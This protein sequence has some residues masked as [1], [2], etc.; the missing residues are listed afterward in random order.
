MSNPRSYDDSITDLR[1][2]A[3]RWAL[4]A[5]D[6]ARESKTHT[7]QRD[8][9][10]AAHYR[11]MAETYYK[12]ALELAEVVKTMPTG[13][14]VVAAPQTVDAPP[15]P[16]ATPYAAVSINE[17]MRI[18]D[19]AG[20]SARDVKQHKDNVFSA[21]FSRWQPVSERE[22]IEQITRFD[23]RIVI[24]SS[25]LLPDTKDPYI[26]FAFREDGM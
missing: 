11:G 17:A 5:R 6:Y 20:V 23:Q 13:A 3:N 22:R 21:V 24:L 14:P 16:Q 1:G 25:G 18:L 26:D 19:Y 2:L 8:E 12:L 15:V 4:L 7:E 10:K 9:V